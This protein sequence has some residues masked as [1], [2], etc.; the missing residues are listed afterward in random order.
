MSNQLGQIEIRHG[1]HMI[2]PTI[3]IPNIQ[4]ETNNTIQYELIYPSIVE[5][6]FTKSLILPVQLK[7]FNRTNEQ[8]Q[9]QLQLIR[10]IL[11]Y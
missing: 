10:L 6:K 3:E 11:F 9:L 4:P 2:S 8:I 1:L 5:H 7:L